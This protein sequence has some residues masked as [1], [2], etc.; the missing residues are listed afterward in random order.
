MDGYDED[1]GDNDFDFDQVWDHGVMD[2][3]GFEPAPERGDLDNIHNA[4]AGGGGD[5]GDEHANPGRGISSGPHGGAGAGP[6][7][8]NA[9]ATQGNSN[10]SDEDDADDADTDDADDAP[11]KPMPPMPMSA[12]TITELVACRAATVMRRAAMLAQIREARDKQ[13]QCNMAEPENRC[14][15][16]ISDENNIMFV[17]WNN[18]A[19]FH[20]RHQSY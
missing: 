9:H 19:Q 6:A 1:N 16:L 8:E 2:D 10:E 18:A 13:A 14:I 5:D 4:A 15:A 20:G 12:D 17:Y 3:L 11:E 7:D